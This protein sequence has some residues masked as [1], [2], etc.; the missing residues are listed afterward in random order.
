ME[1][2]LWDIIGRRAG[3][4]VYKLLGGYQ[5]GVPA[6]CATGE[7]RSVEARVEDAR[8]AMGEGF[9]AIKSRFHHD[10]PRDDLGVVRALRDEVGEKLEI[11]V[12]ANQAGVEPGLSGHRTWGSQTA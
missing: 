5:D 12:D 2:P 11:I 9:R 4:P 6:Y 7:V 1:I 10:D 8:R 3:L